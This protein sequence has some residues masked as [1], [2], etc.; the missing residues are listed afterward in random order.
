MG[1]RVSTPEQVVIK[2]VGE[3]QPI[4]I[5][6]VLDFIKCYKAFKDM[7]TQERHDFVEGCEGVVVVQEKKP[8]CVL[9]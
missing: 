1:R 4:S 3:R 7:T 6:R 9:K 2:V 5:Y 8:M